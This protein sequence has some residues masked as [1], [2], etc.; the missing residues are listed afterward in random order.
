MEARLSFSVL[1]EGRRAR[2][3]DCA[4]FIVSLFQGS[5]FFFSSL[6]NIAL[7]LRLMGAVTEEFCASLKLPSDY[8]E[9]KVL[10][11]EEI[12]DFVIARAQS[13][14]CVLSVP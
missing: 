8:R 3:C 7:C 10:L 13:C 4:T 1:T 11:S 2:L 6:I 9:K 14:A 5:C 12:Q